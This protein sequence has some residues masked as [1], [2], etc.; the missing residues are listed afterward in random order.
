MEL[1]CQMVAKNDSVTSR[2]ALKA[3]MKMRANLF[4]KDEE[5]AFAI[6]GA[7]MR[8]MEV[9]KIW[10]FGLVVGFGSGLGFGSGFG[11]GIGFGFGLGL[12]LDRGFGLGLGLG[13]G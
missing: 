3:L 10:A 4:V 12:N 6:Y 2:V 5:Y 13:L 7:M 9:R 1:A 8:L 11:L